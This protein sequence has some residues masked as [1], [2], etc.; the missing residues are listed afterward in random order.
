MRSITR[1]VKRKIWK[2]KEIIRKMKVKRGRKKT[3]KE[4]KLEDECRAV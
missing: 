1:E 2:E 4:I 3:E